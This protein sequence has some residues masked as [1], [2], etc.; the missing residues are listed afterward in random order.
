MNII[1]IV[2][3]G[4]VSFPAR[5]ETS[6]GYR[7]DVPFDNVSLPSLPVSEAI[8][9]QVPL[10][11]GTVIGRAHPAGYLGLVGRAGKMLVMNRYAFTEND[12]L[13]LQD[14]RISCP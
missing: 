14:Y 11:E 1:Q 4:E 3:K 7:Y 8:R 5:L 2:T 6:A 10:P 13:T 9:E 12:T